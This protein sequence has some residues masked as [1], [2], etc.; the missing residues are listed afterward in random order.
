MQSWHEDSKYKKGCNSSKGVLEQIG[1]TL[2]LLH[3][4]GQI[5]GKIELI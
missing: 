5:H 1:F 3:N 2:V 4:Q